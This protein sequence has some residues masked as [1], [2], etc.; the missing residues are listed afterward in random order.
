MPEL[1]ELTFE[2]AFRQLEETV[3]LLESGEL[4]IDEMQSKFERGMALVLQCRQRLDSAQAR[5]SILTKEAE[6]FNLDDEPAEVD[7][8]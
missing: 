4:S 5:V 3:S 1:G 8:P 2:S 6:D 7:D